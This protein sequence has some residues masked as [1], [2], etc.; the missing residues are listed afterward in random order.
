MNMI[1]TYLGLGAILAIFLGIW[2]AYYYYTSTQERIQ[3][4]SAENARLEIE[5]EQTKERERKLIEFQKAQAILIKEANDAFNAAEQ[6][7]SNVI[8]F[9]ADINF[10]GVTPE[11]EIEINNAFNEILRSIECDT[12]NCK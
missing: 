4:L 8:D 5:L 9:F 11:I 10:R 6:V 12:G 1:R 3:E 2:G 7:A